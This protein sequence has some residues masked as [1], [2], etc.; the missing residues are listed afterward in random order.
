MTRY[1]L[2][3]I[4]ALLVLVATLGWLLRAEIKASG[5]LRQERIQLQ[6]S[7]DAQAKSL[8]TVMAT[9]KHTAQLLTE[10]EQQRNRARQASAQLKQR[11][12][13]LEEQANESYRAC[14]DMRIPGP[15]LDELRSSG[16]D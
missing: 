6:Q 5:A 2:Y 13:Q 3:A 9:Q 15:V 16:T 8:S 14:L 7:L 11:I 12:T 10:R 1:L 4:A